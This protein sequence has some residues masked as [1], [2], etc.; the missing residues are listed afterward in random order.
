MS[1]NPKDFDCCPVFFPQLENKKSVKT[2][3]V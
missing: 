1:P 3:L 2:T